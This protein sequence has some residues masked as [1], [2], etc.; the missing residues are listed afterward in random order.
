VKPPAR[1]QITK[2]VQVEWVDST[3]VH[4]WRP[5]DEAREDDEAS[6]MLCRSVG[7]L[8]RDEPDFLVLVQSAAVTHVDARLQIPRVSIRQVHELEAQA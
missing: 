3:H 4:G 2:I 1:D 6:D 5:L 8:L 7:Y